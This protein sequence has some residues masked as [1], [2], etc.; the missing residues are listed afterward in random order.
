MLFSTFYY[1]KQFC[2]SSLQRLGEYKCFWLRPVILIEPIQ[3]WVTIGW[4]VPPI[5]VASWFPTLITIVWPRSWHQS[6]SCAND[7]LFCGN[8]EVG[9]KA[10]VALSRQPGLG[11]YGSYGIVTWSVGARDAAKAGWQGHK[12]E[13]D[14]QRGDERQRPGIS[15]R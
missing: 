9:P 10:R 1:C 5:G 3:L 15:P 13:T 14:L 8:L 4:S 11:H 12:D 6:P 7:S 2:N